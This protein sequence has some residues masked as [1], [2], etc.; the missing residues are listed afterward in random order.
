MDQT[1]AITLSIFFLLFFVTASFGLYIW[2][3]KSIYTRE[4]FALAGL[5]AAS[6]L[7]LFVIASI[8]AQ[9]PPWL[10]AISLIRQLPGLPYQTP[11]TPTP[12]QEILSILLVVGLWWLIMRLHGHW[13]GAQSTAHYEQQQK[14]QAPSLFADTWLLLHAS[15]NRNLLAVYNPENQ[16]RLTALEGA[17]ESLVWHQQARDLLQLSNRQYEFPDDGWHDQ[18]RCW[19]G[20]HKGTGDTVVLACYDRQSDMAA[21]QA[22]ASKMPLTEQVNPS[23]TGNTFDVFLSYNSQDKSLMR[24]LAQALKSR[25]LKVWLDEEQFIP[26]HPC[27]K[28][29]ETIIQTTNAAVV[30]IGDSGLGPWEDQ[31]MRACLMELVKRKLPVIPVLLPNAPTEPELPLFL[32][33]VTWVDLRGGFTDEGLKKIQWGITGVKSE[34]L[35]ATPEEQS[36]QFQALV[37]YAEKVQ[38]HHGRDGKGLEFIFAVKE[39]DIDQPSQ[40]DRY[41][42]RTVSESRLL[43]GLVNFDDYFRD[44]RKRV[45]QDELTGCELTLDKVYT[46]SRYKFD[47][48][49]EEQPDLEAYLNQW[50]QES[51]LR[52]IALLGEYGQ[53]KSTASLMLSYHLMQRIQQNLSPARIPILLELRGKSPRNLRED[54]LLST[55]AGRYGIDTRALIKLLIAGRL[56]LIFEG[57]DEVDL[58]GDS[59][60]RIEHFKIMWG[61]CYP[62][63]KIMVTGRPNY[64]LDNAELKSALGIQDP[65]LER[66]Y[67]QAI[68]MAPFGFREMENSL[69]N[70][71]ADTRDGIIALAEENERFY[72]IVSRPSM[73]H[74]VSILW[75]T[76]NLA[77]YGQRINSALVMDR[78]VRHSLERQGGKGQKFDFTPPTAGKAKP[79][80]MALNSRERAYFMEGIATYMLIHDLPNQIS[81]RELES[82]ARLL[83]DAIPDA[84]SLMDAQSGETRKPLRQR[85]DLLNK[86]EE[87][88]TILTDIRACG[89]LVPDVTR[90]GSFKFGHKSF[91]EFL[92]AK[93]FAQWSLRKE[94]DA[95]EEKAV[96][97]LVN[98]LGLKMRHV[99]GQ[100]EVMAFAVEWIAEKADD[101]KQAARLIFSLLFKQYSITMLFI[102][103]L[104]KI[105]LVCVTYTKNSH[106]M[107][108]LSEKYYNKVGR[109]YTLPEDKGGFVKLILH[110]LIYI[111][112]SVIVVFYFRTEPILFDYE[113]L[114]GKYKILV[115]GVIIQCFMIFVASFIIVISNIFVYIYSSLLLGYK[116]NENHVIWI[117]FRIWHAI[118]TAAHLDR[119]AIASVISEKSLLFLEEVASQEPRP[120]TIAESLEKLKNRPDKP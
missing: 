110:M 79:A 103:F 51:S 35:P 16:Y 20:T 72:D 19:I 3:R 50:L 27:M 13:D 64:F 107:L 70:L 120:W 31:E 116:N 63:A 49:G 102:G 15:D 81:S 80:F 62:K 57:F 24:E 97:S 111:F 101:Q 22:S 105:S 8:Y 52:Q 46:V 32:K 65:S 106:I 43:D 67:C 59:H 34:P 7:T 114:P 29:L 73:L 109:S 45:E 115:I 83:I 47:K 44:L 94:L 4:K 96:S 84:V 75:N 98:K 77:E 58:S 78:F 48:E 38:R 14:Q 53:G 86:P 28:P 100:Q 42:S 82:V 1:L 93:V 76:E 91:M 25:N 119:S 17:E 99:V 26:G 10:A 30:L 95:T 61:L 90:S 117:K 36:N 40:F 54:E 5:A 23:L 71:D 18:A 112:I 108:R 85:Y 12:E 104:L 33:N 60:A 66:P 55:W 69:R 87:A 2:L 92:A 88:Q 74:V 89:L 11:Q 68:H 118:C 21:I 37:K 113:E 41:P 56:L 39:G 9:E 6:T